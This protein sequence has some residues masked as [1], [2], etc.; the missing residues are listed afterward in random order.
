MEVGQDQLILNATN[1][2]REHPLMFFYFFFGWGW[3]VV[4]G[5]AKLGEIG[6]GG[7]KT[8]AFITGKKIQQSH[9]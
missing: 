9:L 3:G 7:L 4:G 1:T 5:E 6:L 2:V 8:V